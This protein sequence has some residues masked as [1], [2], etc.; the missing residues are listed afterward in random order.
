MTPF[1]NQ[2]HHHLAGTPEYMQQVADR[3]QS[4][5]SPRGGMVHQSSLFV[6]DSSNYQLYRP[7]P[8]P[9][10]SGNRR[11]TLPVL[12]T[13]PVIPPKPP[14]T[15]QLL[16]AIQ[17]SSTNSSMSKGLQHQHSSPAPSDSTTSKMSGS[18]LVR[19]P[20]QETSSSVSR[21]TL[22]MPGGGGGLGRTPGLAKI[23]K[24]G[25]INMGASRGS[26]PDIFAAVTEESPL[27]REEVSRLSQERRE[28]V[29]RRKEE[30]E[31][32]RKNPL[33]L[34]F[35]PALREF[36]SR[37]RLTLAVAVINITLIYLFS[38]LLYS[39]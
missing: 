31:R 15:P 2:N 32:M 34:I 9:Q 4:Q 13:D 1:L 19:Q 24:F 29:R 5:N 30:E 37:H 26:M 33:L 16:G 39:R 36:F 20:S 21:P 7:T 17:E 25:S 10:P 28:A 8:A 22:G 12:T 27:S 14:R 35:H 3:L 6:G 38:D 23:P 11:S 18:G